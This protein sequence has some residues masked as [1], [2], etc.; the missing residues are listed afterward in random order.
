MC[1]L[2]GCSGLSLTSEF[3]HL[4]QPRHFDVQSTEEVV[5]LRLDL[6]LVVDLVEVGVEKI[7]GVVRF[8]AGRFGD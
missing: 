7:V 4:R 2:S 8:G 3:L 6:G 1:I 5:D